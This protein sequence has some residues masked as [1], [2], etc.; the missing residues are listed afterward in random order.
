LIATS[1]SAIVVVAVSVSIGGALMVLCGTRAWTWR[2]PPVG[3]A[4]VLVVGTLAARLPGRAATA[5]V[6]IAVVGLAAT[7]I[8]VATRTGPPPVP[9]ALIAAVAGFGAA[10]PFIVNGRVG[11]LGAGLVNDDMA[12]HLVMADW[13]A[14]HA[15]L[16][17]G[18]IADGYPLGPHSLAAALG[19]LPGVDLV[20][21]FAGFTIAIGVLAALT[22]LA[23]LRLRP[24]PWLAAGASLAALSYLGASY[25]AQ[26][27]FK[28]PLMALFLVGF[29]LSLDALDGRHVLRAVVPLGV[30]AAGSLY[31]YSFPALFWLAGTAVLWALLGVAR[32]GAV[33]QALR[34]AVLVGAAIVAGIALIANLPELAR[35]ERF[36]GF[37]AFDPGT[38]GLGNLAH[39]LSPLEALGV[40]PTSDFRVS[41][42]D[43][44]APEL[45]FYAGAALA[46]G[47]LAAGA[48]RVWRGDAIGLLAALGAAALIYVG[49]AATV[50][51]YASGKA[52]AI[53]A[54]VAMLV[55]LRALPDALGRRGTAPAW[56]MLAAAFV[57]AAGLSSFL[58][59][60]HGVVGP[61]AHLRELAQI[62]PLVAGEKLLFLGRDNFVLYELRGSKPFTH[63]RNFY[64]P[65][66]VKPNFE[67]RNVGFKFDFDSVTADKLARFPY[68]LTTRASYA[69]GPPPSWEAVKTTDSYVL[70]RQGRAPLG[71]EPVED[72]PAPTAEL[73]CGR[74]RL[75]R[76]DRVAFAAH[77]PVRTDAAEW[78]PSTTIEDGAPATITL[79]LPPGEW[80]L[81]LQYDS[82]RPITLNGPGL[83]A[84]LP[85][86]LDYRGAAPYWPAGRISSEGR[87]LVIEASVERPPLAGRMMGAN[88][89]AHLGAVGGTAAGPPYQV[90][91]APPHPGLGERQA[92]ARIVC[93]RDAD[94][95]APAR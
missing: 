13:V 66:F 7:A 8:L 85:G 30:I 94:W 23:V 12:S 9:A 15:G 81:S 32:S 82:T 33:R 67:I 69:S 52:L 64:D 57:G 89:V 28:E 83:E 88:S 90:G 41:A 37:K 24:L 6:A 16:E 74:G 50:T 36:A 38:D 29:A 19:E 73:K 72:D 3:L 49:S 80:E 60:R 95:I 31:A 58:A 21:A 84:E 68:V 34:P 70:W 17:P 4:A 44:A 87:P 26:G 39:P 62:R 11:V 75:A 14:T 47:F 61:Q 45:L 71:R 59:L 78:S 76:G 86:N 92:P 27:A 5:L 55:A 40:W 46:A 91:L 20:E 43:A 25:L 56:S 54:P 53:A 48:L 35:I 2:S 18:L 51:A 77:A 42:A 1:I 10:L 22:A 79:D 65:Y 93:G 63:V